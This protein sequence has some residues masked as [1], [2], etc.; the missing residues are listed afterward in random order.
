MSIW[1]REPAIVT[2]SAVAL[3]TAILTLLVA[4]GIDIDPGQQA[5]IVGAVSA[6]LSTAALLTTGVVI[7]AQVTPSSSVVE[8]TDGH[9]S[10]VA[11]AAS[12]LPTGQRIRAEGSLDWM[13]ADPRNALDADGDGLPD[14][15]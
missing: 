14:Y 15:A 9:G 8:R 12:E 1:R 11:G 4:Y 13:A 5:A 10:V 7:R 2:A 3:A 6:A